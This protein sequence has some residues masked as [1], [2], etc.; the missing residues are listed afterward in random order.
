V[1]WL[2][3]AWLSLCDSSRYLSMEDFD[4]IGGMEETEQTLEK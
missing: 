2:G 4:K 1:H 3:L